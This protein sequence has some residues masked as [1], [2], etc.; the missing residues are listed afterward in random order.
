MF[1][2][3]TPSQQAAE[4]LNTAGFTVFIL[5]EGCMLGDNHSKYIVTSHHTW[6]NLLH[7]SFFIID[8]PQSIED[9]V[10]KPKTIKTQYT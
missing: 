6:L 9:T 10:A 7:F 5:P 8:S 3:Y 4:K 1:R 2:N